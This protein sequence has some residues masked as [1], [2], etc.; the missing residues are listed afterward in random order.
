MS[1]EYTYE[2]PLD[3]YTMFVTASYQ[4]AFEP[5]IEHISFIPELEPDHLS[6]GCDVDVFTNDTYSSLIIRYLARAK[7]DGQEIHDRI[8]NVL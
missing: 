2:I 3:G 8:M 1:R 5:E 6:F 4:P 7:I